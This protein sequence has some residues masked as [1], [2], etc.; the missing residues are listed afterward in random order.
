M[1]D[2]FIRAM[3]IRANRFPF[4]DRI[5]YRVVCRI[6]VGMRAYKLT[7]RVIHFIRIIIIIMIPK[8][9]D[10]MSCY[11]RNDVQPCLLLLAQMYASAYYKC[12][13]LYM[14]EK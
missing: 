10:I 14:G 5:T 11:N 6:S 4:T 8:G 12:T 3:Y 7:P 9:M 1:I 13:R 2:R